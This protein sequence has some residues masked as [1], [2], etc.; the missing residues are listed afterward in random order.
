MSVE[1]AT[2]RNKS[3][4][5]VPICP[6]PVHLSSN[7]QSHADQNQSTAG[8]ATDAPRPQQIKDLL[9]GQSVLTRHWAIIQW[10]KHYIDPLLLFHDELGHVIH[11]PR[12]FL[13]LERTHLAYIRTSNVIAL[14]G[15]VVAQL[16]VL[17]NADSVHGRW[18]ATGIYILAIALTVAS[19]VRTIWLQDKITT[20]RTATPGWQFVL[21]SLLLLTMLVVALILNAR[22]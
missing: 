8:A 5:E 11:D 17:N 21:L 15:V 19:G 16:F 6:E 20:G 7:D 4:V 22:S 14:F 2:T 3:K 10:W 9:A 1:L 12:D 18:L 13:A